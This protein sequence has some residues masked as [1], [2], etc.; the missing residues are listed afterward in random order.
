[1]LVSSNKCTTWIGSPISYSYLKNKDWR[2]CVDYTDFNKACKKICS[3]CPESIM[4]WTPRPVAT[5]WVFLIVSQA[6]IRLPSKN[7]TKSRCP[8]SLHS[9]LFVTQW[10]HS[11]LKVQVQ[12]IKG[13]YNGVYTLNSSATLKCMLTMWSL[14]LKK[15]SDSSLIWQRPLSTWESSKL[16]WTLR[17]VRL[18]CPQENYS[19]IWSPI[20]ESTLT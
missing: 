15:M 2:M 1:M 8:S 10:C 6:I 18:V 4:S 9:V 5:L 19:G 16:S 12:H 13:V 17:S 11:D 14:R 7:K 3:T 20:T